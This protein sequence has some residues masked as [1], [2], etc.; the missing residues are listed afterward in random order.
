MLV[1]CSRCGFG[2]NVNDNAIYTLCP[3]C[4]E[5]VTLRMTTRGGERNAILT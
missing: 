5:S 4:G 3:K 2:W 1:R